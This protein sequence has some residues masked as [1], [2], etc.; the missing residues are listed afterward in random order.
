[1]GISPTFCVV[2]RINASFYNVL[3]SLLNC[4][5]VTATTNCPLCPLGRHL[6]ITGV[7]SATARRALGCTLTFHSR[8]AWHQ[9]RTAFGRR[10]AATLQWHCI[11]RCVTF[12]DGVFR[13]PIWQLQPTLGRWPRHAA[14]RDRARRT[15][16]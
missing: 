4:R 8:I 11:H 5:C 10:H 15:T 7:H 13:P 2:V 12:G 9:Q 3:F 1:M 14:R 6:F 16:L